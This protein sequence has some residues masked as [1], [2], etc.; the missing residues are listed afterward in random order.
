[1]R[2]THRRIRLEVV[3]RYKQEQAVHRR[4][5]LVRMT[6]IAEELDLPD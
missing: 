3:M 5:E 2:D 1:M 6:E 4:H